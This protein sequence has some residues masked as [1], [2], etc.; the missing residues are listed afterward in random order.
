MCH[1]QTGRPSFHACLAFDFFV[2][3]HGQLQAS[4][5]TSP[6][7]TSPPLPLTPECQP[8]VRGPGPS[9]CSILRLDSTD[10]ATV[11]L[12][13][14]PND[15]DLVTV[16][17]SRSARSRAAEPLRDADC[18]RRNK[19]QYK[20]PRKRLVSRSGSGHPGLWALQ[21]SRRLRSEPPRSLPFQGRRRHRRGSSSFGGG[22]V[23]DRRPSRT[24]G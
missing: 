24:V 1:N 10:A 19:S 5:T 11:G 9:L 6:R 3:Q 18:P 13:A 8:T 22:R 7:H 12:L 4:A 20:E 2:R 21:T 14:K 23:T 17:A 16:P 15:S